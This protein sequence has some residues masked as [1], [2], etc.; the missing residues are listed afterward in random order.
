MAGALTK[1]EFMYRNPYRTATVRGREEFKS[2][3]RLRSR[4]RKNVACLEGCYRTATLKGDED[5]RDARTT[6]YRVH[7]RVNAVID[8]ASLCSQECEHGTHECVRYGA[9]STGGL[10]KVMK[11]RRAGHLKSIIWATVLLVYPL[12]LLIAAD[13]SWMSKPIQQWDEEDAKQILTNSPWVRHAKPAILPQLTEDQR[14]EGGQM[15]GGKGVGLQ[16]VGGDGVFA[17]AQNPEAARAKAA[18]GYA[19]ALTVRWES[20]LPVRVA[21]VKA[22]EIGAPDWEGEFYAVAVYDVPGLKGGSNELNILKR[23]ALLKR[24]GKKDIKPERVNVLQ[25]ANGLAIVVYLFPR[26]DEITRDDKRVRFSAQIARLYLERDFDTGEM[27][28]Q[29]KMQL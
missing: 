17:P 13:P 4:F 8:S 14:R 25:R 23:S 12:T 9:S 27:E 6:R 28:F 10:P 11:T 1:R 5:A 26:T 15:G 21:E 7:A 29:G 19:D 16:G 3:G 24:E 22:N 18:S 20:A 2:T